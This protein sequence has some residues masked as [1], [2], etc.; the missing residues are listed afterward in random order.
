MMKLKIIK[1]SSFPPVGE[2]RE[3]RSFRRPE[4]KP[5]LVG[6]EKTCGPKIKLGL[7]PDLLHAVHLL[8][9]EILI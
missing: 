4:P 6:S 1:Y 7:I 8:N 2:K 9:L 5:S 3:R